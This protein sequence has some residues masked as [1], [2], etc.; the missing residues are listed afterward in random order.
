[1]SEFR[2]TVLGD[3]CEGLLLRSAESLAAWHERKHQ[4][5]AAAILPARHRPVAHLS[6]AARPGLAALESTSKKNP[7]ISNSCE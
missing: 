5:A 1:M 6:S 4:P 3:G 7:G 2:K